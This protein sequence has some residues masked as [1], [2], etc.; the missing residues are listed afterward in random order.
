MN[1]QSKMDLAEVFRNPAK[2]IDPSDPVN[3][4]I[5]KEHDHRQEELSDREKREADELLAQ[6]P[7]RDALSSL[8]T[9]DH[10]VKQHREDG[11]NWYCH[12]HP[13]KWLA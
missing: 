2:E 10:P 11:E 8:E 3:A 9:L 5:L 13:G 12:L 4:E 1:H 7:V 6:R